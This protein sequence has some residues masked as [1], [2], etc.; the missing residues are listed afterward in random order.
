MNLPQTCRRALTLAVL[1][2][3]AVFATTVLMAA[4]TPKI[5]PVPK[6][7]PAPE[8]SGTTVAASA[9]EPFLPAPAGWQ[10]IR[11]GSNHVEL[12]PGCDYAF[13]EA[14]FMNEAMKV[15]ITVADTGLHQEGLA[16]FASM[17]VAFPDGYEGKIPPDTTITRFQFKEAP[18]AA[19]WDAGPGE[20]EFVVVIGGRF[21]A[22]AEGNVDSLDTLKKIVGLIDLKKL[23]ELK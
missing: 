8:K 21:V 20:G 10:K 16:V 17:V 22:K 4:Q 18:A 7:A 5:A 12:S 3:G 15:R 11:S 13:A 2:A 6:V 23:G 1:T 9:L 19:R 14:V